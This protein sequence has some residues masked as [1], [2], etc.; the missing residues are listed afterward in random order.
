MVDCFWLLDKKKEKWPSNGKGGEAGNPSVNGDY[1]YCLMC[2]DHCINE[3]EGQ[4]ESKIVN[5]IKDIDNE[6][7]KTNVKSETDK[8]ENKNKKY[9]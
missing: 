5:A 4:N 6:E 3:E 9:M 7:V 1:E 2:F 8:I